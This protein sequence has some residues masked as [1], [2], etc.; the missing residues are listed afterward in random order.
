MERP[1]WIGDEILAR[2]PS[3]G[4]STHWGD[5]SRFLPEIPPQLFLILSNIPFVRPFLQ[6]ERTFEMI[7]IATT[8]PGLLPAKTQQRT[9]LSIHAPL[10]P[11]PW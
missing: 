1:S 6:H 11:Y 9:L 4:H 7:T 2:G 10:W 5:L 3:S 8:S